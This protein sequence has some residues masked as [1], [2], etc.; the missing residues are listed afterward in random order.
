MIVC[1]WTTWDDVVPMHLIFE[2]RVLFSRL[3]SLACCLQPDAIAFSEHDIGLLF[4][5]DRF[6][7]SSTENA[8]ECECLHKKLYRISGAELIGLIRSRVNKTQSDMKGNPIH[9]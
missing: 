9:G 3:L 4:M 5:P 6:C 1:V 2:R 8:P 7:E